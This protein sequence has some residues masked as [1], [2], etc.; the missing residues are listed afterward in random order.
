M[1]QA[2]ALVIARSAQRDEAISAAHE[3]VAEI[4]SLRSQ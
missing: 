2:I 1:A 4:A 3:I